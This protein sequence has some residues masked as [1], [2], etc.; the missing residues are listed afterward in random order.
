M[1]YVIDE[2]GNRVESLSKEEILST[3]QQAIDNKSLE[4]IDADSAFVSKLKCCVGGDTF[5]MAFVTQAKYNELKTQNKLVANTLYF[6]TDDTTE[7]NLEE[8]I[9][10]HNT[11]LEA[12]DKTIGEIQKELNSRSK[13]TNNNGVLYFGNNIITQKKKIFEQETTVAFGESTTLSMSETINNGDLI[14]V[15][16]D[17]KIF[18][19]RTSMVGRFYLDSDTSRQGSLFVPAFS[20]GI[21]SKSMGM[22]EVE[23]ARSYGKLWVNLTNQSFVNSSGTPPIETDK[24]NI[25]TSVQAIIKKVYKVIE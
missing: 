6:I 19:T 10:A 21:N 24:A 25:G 18:A 15:H 22:I 1:N 13:I 8:S 12:F 5:G 7:E 16:C 11:E 4:G 17:V 3:M 23:F 9:E 2:N 20:T 14:E